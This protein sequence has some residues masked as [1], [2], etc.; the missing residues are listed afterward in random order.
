MSNNG[1]EATGTIPGFPELPAD[2]E[3]FYTFDSSNFPGDFL[4]NGPPTSPATA[5][6]ID[7]YLPPTSPQGQGLLTFEGQQPSPDVPEPI[8]PATAPTTL[9]QEVAAPLQE[10]VPAPIAGATGMTAKP[11]SPRRSTSPPSNPNRLIAPNTPA[12]GI[13]RPLE[14]STRETRETTPD[15]TWSEDVRTSAIPTVTKGPLGVKKTIEAKKRA[16]DLAKARGVAGRNQSPKAS[17]EIVQH[18]RRSTR[19]RLNK[20][21][22]GAN[23]RL[24]RL[25]P[26]KLRYND[27]KCLPMMRKL[28]LKAI[29]PDAE[30]VAV[31][32]QIRRQAPQNITP[33]K[34]PHKQENLVK[35]QPKE[36]LLEPR[37]KKFGLMPQTKA[38]L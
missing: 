25:Y 34:D 24:S 27:S 33:M 19:L 26:R 12:E 11:R 28:I 2:M 22:P 6:F 8:A 36:P 31:I 23:K 38:N 35:H 18:A 30:D 15:A 10:L 21:K 1:A 20:L 7:D 37:T 29:Q 9:F 32:P 14:D 5:T 4:N 17:N 16:N 13:R 3:N